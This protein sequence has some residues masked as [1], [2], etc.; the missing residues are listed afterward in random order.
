MAEAIITDKRN[1]DERSETIGSESTSEISNMAASN[2]TSSRAGKKKKL[3][4]PD[5]LEKRLDALEQSLDCKFDHLFRLYKRTLQ[6][7]EMPRGV[8]RTKRE[9]ALRLASVLPFRGRMRIMSRYTLATQR[10]VI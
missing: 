7:V 3:S 1:S 8:F 9:T 4:K 5:L 10:G 2:D 6:P